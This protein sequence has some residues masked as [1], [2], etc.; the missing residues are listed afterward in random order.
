MIIDAP[1]RP[2]HG[3][4]LADCQSKNKNSEFQRHLLSVASNL[5]TCAMRDVVS[6]RRTNSSLFSNTL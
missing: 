3:K 2:K 1:A 4:V 5:T 6:K